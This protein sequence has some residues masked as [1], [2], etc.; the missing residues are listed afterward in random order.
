MLPIE[1]E[2]AGARTVTFD[3]HLGSGR[4]VHME[5]VA[6]P[7]MVSFDSTLALLRGE[8]LDPN[9]ITTRSQMA[10]GLAFPRAGDARRLVETWLAAIGINRER[11]SILA[12]AVDYLEL[13]EADLQHFYCL[14][15]A[16]WPRGVLSTRRLAVL[17]EGLRRRPESLFWAETSSEFD[18]L[19]S[20]SIIL[21]GI[22][23]ALTGQQHPLLTARKDRES[24]AEKQAAMARMQARGLSAG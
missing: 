2:A 4:T 8:G 12:R 6:D 22:F 5:G 18:P 11:L 23:G 14:D 3:V 13:V 20:E 16:D 10:W 1:V 21:A 9:F 15:L 17:M 24:A 7:I 19:T